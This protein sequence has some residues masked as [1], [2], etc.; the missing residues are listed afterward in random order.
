[1]ARILSTPK[2]AIGQSGS[3]TE[4]LANIARVFPNRN[5]HGYILAY[6]I[7]E[8]RGGEERRVSDAFPTHEAASAW[9]A[10]HESK[11]AIAFFGY[12]VVTGYATTA[13]GALIKEVAD[14]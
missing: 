1:M 2:N 8:G 12:R 4:Y 14:H 13:K 7:Y 9:L 3:R 6:Y 5:R 11:A 10:E